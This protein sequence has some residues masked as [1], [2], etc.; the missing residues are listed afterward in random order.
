MTAFLRRYSA[1]LVIGGT[2]LWAA[3]AILFYRREQAPPDAIVLRIG[4]WQL[5]ASVREA[6]D[7]MAERYR[8]EVNPR[9]RI[10]QDAIPEMV[11]GQWLTT[12]LMGGTAPD[13]LEMGI[14]VPYHVLVQY[15]N[16]YFRPLTPHVNAPNPYNAG[17]SLDGVPLRLTIKDGMRNAYLEEMQEYM[18]I[19]LSQFGVRIFYNRDL[20]R[21][22]TGLEQAPDDY[23]AFLA[24]CETIGARTAPDGKPYVPI[25]SSKYHLTSMWEPMMFDPVTYPLHREADFNRDGFVANYELYVAFRTGRVSFQHPAV[26]ARY[27]ML[28]EISSHFQTGYTGLTRDEAVFLFA[29][30]RAVF[31]STGTWDARSLEQQARGQFE[32]GV[33]DFPLPTKDDP[34]YGP[35]I[36]GPAYERPM[37]GFPFA[38]TRTCKHPEVALDFLLFLAGRDNNEALNRMIGWI[39]STR[40]TAMDPLLEAFEPHLVGVYSCLNLFLGGET[41]VRW[42]QMYSLYQVQQI[43]YETLAAEFEPFY[44]EQGLKDFEE[45]ARDWRR[46]MHNNEL[47]LAGLRADALTAPDAA[48]A[49]SAWVKYRTLTAGRQVWPEINHAKEIKLV[50]GELAVPESAPY[51][52][53]PAVLE[54]VRLRLKTDSGAAALNPQATPL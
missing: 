1:L 2:F 23:R 24:A 27:R 34:V 31:I 13:M 33:M 12:Q 26:E 49:E 16:R 45:T 10:I 8:R 11:Y 46:G 30:E 50:R 19:P 17:T 20:L 43:N 15:Y 35:I 44:K 21:A 9:V 54:R 47:F 39:P 3:G 36:E 37:G 22:L 53:G 40:D 5:E 42:L 41:W 7:E 51:E 6:L 29:Q 52:H 18:S 14:G 32:V 48:A 4:H 25:A 28:R 38:I